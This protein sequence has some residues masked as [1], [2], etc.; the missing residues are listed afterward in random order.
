MEEGRRV[1]WRRAEDIEDAV[2]NSA[3]TKEDPRKEDP[4]METAVHWELKKRKK[5]RKNDTAE[6]E[7]V[8][9]GNTESCA[10]WIPQDAFAESLNLI[11]RVIPFQGSPRKGTLSVA[12]PASIVANAQSPEL[13][14]ALVGQIARTLVIMGVEEIIIYEDRDLKFAGLQNPL[15]APHHLRRS[16]WL[17]YREGV[18]L[19][20]PPKTTK[21]CLVE[22]GLAVPVTCSQ[23]IPPGTRVTLR[24]HPAMRTAGDGGRLSAAKKEAIFKGEAVS[25]QE[26]PTRAGLYWGYQVRAAASLREVFRG[27][28]LD[29]SSGGLYDCLVG[30]SERG[31]ALGDVAPTLHH[32]LLV[33]GGVH[34]LE[35]VIQDPQAGVPTAEART[36][37]SQCLEGRSV[38]ASEGLP[39]DLRRASKTLS[40]Q[41]SPGGPLHS[42]MEGNSTDIPPSCLFD[43]YVNTCPMQSSRT[44]R[45][46]EA[47]LV[48]LA[49]MRQAGIHSRCAFQEVGDTCS[50]KRRPHLP[51]LFRV[52]ESLK[53]KAQPNET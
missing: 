5:E 30:T 19:Q 13:K 46:E 6:G 27:H 10:S 36:A 8:Q 43:E 7:G 22:C 1:K 11:P 48:S 38:G 3:E 25:P 14:A 4:P 41:G 24:L 26:P 37:V 29:G 23:R 40:R 34:G 49:A 31:E 28:A 44:I 17:P 50:G 47:L 21:G 9:E 15:D 52:M 42:F 33:F 16:E 18:V 2:S 51:P 53:A 32:L 45:A 39:S 20:D 12:L 35:E